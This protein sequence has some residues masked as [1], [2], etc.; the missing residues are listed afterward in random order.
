[1]LAMLLAGGF[2]PHKVIIADTAPAAV[3]V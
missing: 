2:K 3:K 1:M